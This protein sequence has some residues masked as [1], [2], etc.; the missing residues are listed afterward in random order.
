MVLDILGGR[1]RR[2]LM[3][4]QY[5]ALFDCL[6]HANRRFGGF[7]FAASQSGLISQPRNIRNLRFPPRQTTLTAGVH[8]FRFAIILHTLPGKNIQLPSIVFC[9]VRCTVY[10]TIFVW[11]SVVF[12]WRKSHL[13][14]H[15]HTNFYITHNHTHTRY[16]ALRHSPSSSSP[17]L[18]GGCS[19]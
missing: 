4:I 14:P 12:C 18:S 19:R 11:Q 8:T 1:C 3:M 17:S 16:I 13:Q 15:I 10:R 5:A 2:L 6:I 9:T 7:S